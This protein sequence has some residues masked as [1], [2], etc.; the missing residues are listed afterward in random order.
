MLKIFANKGTDEKIAVYCHYGQIQDLMR[1]FN[2]EFGGN[3]VLVDE[4]ATSTEILKFNDGLL[5]E[6]Y[7]QNIDR[8]SNFIKKFKFKN[9]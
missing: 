3:W 2:S 4:V 7:S 8:Y 9:A 5:Y 1:A 6:G